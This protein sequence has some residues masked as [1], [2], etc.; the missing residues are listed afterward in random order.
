M[1]SS[2]MIFIRDFILVLVTLYRLH[3]RVVMG[4][5]NQYL[6]IRKLENSRA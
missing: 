2:C 3:M 6:E 4:E 1:S 5:Q